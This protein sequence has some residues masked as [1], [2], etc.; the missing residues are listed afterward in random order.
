MYGNSSKPRTSICMQ[1]E[2]TIQSL[3]YHFRVLQSAFLHRLAESRCLQSFLLP[4][5]CSPSGSRGSQEQ[6]QNLKRTRENGGTMKMRSRRMRADNLQEET[7]SWRANHCTK[8]W[9]RSLKPWPRPPAELKAPAWARPNKY[10]TVHCCTPHTPPPTRVWKTVYWTE[11][12]GT[13]GRR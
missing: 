2:G 10:L 6:H 8:T 9:W 13:R 12:P 3:V 1:D 5:I 11:G 7:P 4:F